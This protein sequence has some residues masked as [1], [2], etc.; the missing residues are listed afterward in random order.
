[1]KI[2]P[3][4]IFRNDFCVE[5]VAFQEDQIMFCT[6]GHSRAQIIDKKDISICVHD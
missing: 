5:E 1:M 3:S 2:I 6:S 4:Y